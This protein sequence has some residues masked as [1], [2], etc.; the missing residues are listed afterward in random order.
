MF[1]IVFATLLI[2]HG[3][4]HLLYFGHCRRIFELRP[5]MTWPAVDVQARAI[6]G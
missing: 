6:F 3:G 2:L 5:G 4:V 1:K